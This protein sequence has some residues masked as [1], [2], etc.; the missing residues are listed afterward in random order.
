LKQFQRSGQIRDLPFKDLFRFLSAKLF[1]RFS[2]NLNFCGIFVVIL[3]L[4][5]G[6]CAF[7]FRGAQKL[8]PSL[9]WSSLKT[10]HFVI[11]FHAGEEAQG[12]KAA[13]FAE[14]IHA[15]L[16]EKLAWP[17]PSEKTHIV[18]L[19]FTD[20]PFGATI[21]FPHNAIYIGLTPPFASPLPFLVDYDD[22]LKEVVAHEYVHILHLDMHNGTSS[23][24]RKIFGREPFPLF[25]FNGAFPN[26]I[27]PD[28]LIEGLATYEESA[29]G[30]SDR[31]DNPYTEM[32][33]RMAVLDNHFPTID[34]TGGMESWPGNQLQY[35]FG[36]RFYQYLAKRFGE[37]VLMK[38]SREYSQK[39]GPFFVDSTAKIILGETYTSLWNQWKEELA[40][41]T[42]RTQESITKEGIT[43]TIALTHRGDYTLGPR[44]SPD[45]HSLVYTSFNEDEFPSL[46]I[47]DLKTGKDHELIRR[48]LGYGSS[49]S[50][51]GKKLAFAQLD[52]FNNY[53]EYSDLYLYDFERDHIH[54]LTYGK[55]V[56]EPD[57]SPDG[58]R[59]IAIE[60]E[61]GKS[62][63]ILYHLDSGLIEPIVWTDSETIFS[64]PRWSSDG[65]SIVVSG[66]KKG[67]TGLFLLQ[68]D[69]KKMTPLLLDHFMNLT[70]VW[71]PNGENV[72]F[73]SDR[74]GIYNLYS[75]NLESR[76]FSQL[77]H[78]LG[79]AFTPEVSPD[80]AEIIF[81]GY[82]SRGFDLYKMNYPSKVTPT[83]DSPVIDEKIVIEDK[84]ADAL[85]PA[86]PYSSWPTVLPRFWMPLVG[87]DDSGLQIGGATA[88]TDVLGRHRYDALLLYGL[89]SHR[90]AASIQYDNNSFYPTLH[91]GI[92]YMPVVYP[93]L[94]T[95]SQGKELDYWESRTRTILDISYLWNHATESTLIRGGYTTDS[96]SAI[97]T[98]PQTGP[99]PQT[100]SLRGLQASYLFN[101]SKEF[102]FSISREKGRTIQIQYSWFTDQLG[103]DFNQNRT[104]ASWHEY[105]PFFFDHHLIAGRLTAGSSTGDLLVQRAFQVGG[106]DF[107]EEMIKPDQGD[108][109]LRGYS[110]RLL[111][112]N[113]AA[114][115]SMEYRFPIYN[116]ERGFRSWPFFF[117]RVHGALFFDIGNAWDQETALP[118]FKRGFGAEL[119]TDL[120]FSYL[121]PLRLRLGVGRGVDAMGVTQFYFMTGNSF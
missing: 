46:R 106:P 82:H 114:V 16:V 90:P 44:V 119:K 60:N 67:L 77:T 22:W 29:L 61:N 45:G 2:L 58:I 8:N 118:E 17:P 3:S 52:F 95:N 56:R 115:G 11:Y 87:G 100:G 64:H 21:P 92:D 85:S 66:W 7:S 42:F 19:D 69:Q 96:F 83:L 28:W 109:F 73:S 81:S 37:P 31:R 91:L 40:A 80:G 104:V 88:G 62:R 54:R 9:T 99:Q 50:K 89:S 93:D 97:S 63:M 27:Q 70:P 76:A 98:I 18:L 30:V 120:T 72:V 33:L 71:L 68:M 43:E 4:F 47:L 108:F 15:H 6:G 38:L 103:S 65:K 23:V 49:W 113:R 121:I 1:G 102:G 35:L 53:S 94:L 59:L 74:S 57:F 110:I 41:S 107:T 39:V 116:I 51:D 14:E 55:R 111:R 86:D 117:K 13:R 101:S 26:L 36:A 75:L 48:N 32:I 112:G 78:L 84:N 10:E 105:I 25:V 5:A 24:V 20:S 79:G 12:K 34:Q